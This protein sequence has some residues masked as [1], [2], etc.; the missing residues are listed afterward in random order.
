MQETNPFIRIGMR[1][2][3]EEG[4]QEGMQLGMQRGIQQGLHDGEA[5][6]VVRQLRRRFGILPVRQEDAVRA[7]SSTDL[8]ELAEA[9][10]DFQT[11][12]DLASWLESRR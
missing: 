7:L 1:K 8:E 3:R 9:L 10:L 2:G 6:I 5:G 11:S 12:T 4:I